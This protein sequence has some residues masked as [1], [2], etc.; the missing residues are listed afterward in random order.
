MFT[1]ITSVDLDAL[2]DAI[3]FFYEFE[4][5]INYIYIDHV[6]GLDAVNTKFHSFILYFILFK[7]RFLLKKDYYSFC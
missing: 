5:S 4:D 6:M 1:L 7:E 2:K 3:F